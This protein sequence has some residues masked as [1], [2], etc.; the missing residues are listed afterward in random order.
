M[1]KP[2]NEVVD[3][4]HQLVGSLPPGEGP[5]KQRNTTYMEKGRHVL[6]VVLALLHLLR[7]TRR[8]ERTDKEADTREE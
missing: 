7:S 4:K 6:E 3:E 1:A 5:T 2:S 8:L